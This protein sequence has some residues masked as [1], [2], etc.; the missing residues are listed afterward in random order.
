MG[1]LPDL[2][3]EDL[4]WEHVVSGQDCPLC[5]GRADAAPYWSRVDNLSVSTLYLH[6][7]QRFRGFSQLIFTP[8]HV[9]GIHELSEEEYAA[10]MRDL[11]QVV[12]ALW[13]VCKPDH[14]NHLCEGNFVPHLHFNIIPR[15]KH[16]VRW[17][18]PMHFGWASKKEFWA[19]GIY[20]SEAEHAALRALL[21]DRLRRR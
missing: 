11:R 8:R 1:K 2:G 18:M 19:A 10:Y 12:Q 20:P 5:D 13:D 14:M 4:P 9:T 17:R 7:D 15:Y 16:D 21:H 6:R 3:W